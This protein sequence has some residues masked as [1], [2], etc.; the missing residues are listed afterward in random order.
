[1]T[2]TCRECAWTGAGDQDAY[3]HAVVLQHT[4]RKPSPSLHPSPTVE[5]P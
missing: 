3:L 4:A 1:M 5:Q 2:W